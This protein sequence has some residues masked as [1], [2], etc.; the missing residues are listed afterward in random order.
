MSLWYPAK[1]PIQY[2]LMAWPLTL[3]YNSCDSDMKWCWYWCW[4]GTH[5]FYISYWFRFSAC[6]LVT[7]HR[8]A[9]LDQYHYDT[10]YPSWCW[11]IFNWTQNN[12]YKWNLDQKTWFFFQENSFQDIWIFRPLFGLNVLKHRFLDME[13]DMK[14]YYRCLWKSFEN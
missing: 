5:I 10:Y 12:K 8:I 6:D 2:S 9:E 14:Y 7:P 3:L 11:L 13:Q 1:S 4:L